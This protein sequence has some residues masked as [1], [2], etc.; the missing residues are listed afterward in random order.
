M[1]EA[2]IKRRVA[3]KNS[4]DEQ[5]KQLLR[6]TACRQQERRCR[7]RPVILLTE[8]MPRKKNFPSFLPL[9]CVCHLRAVITRYC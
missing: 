7:R 2:K 5:K 6:G 1:S 8:G 3:C 4:S 9:Q